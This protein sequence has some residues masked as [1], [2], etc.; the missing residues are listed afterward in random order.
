[1]VRFKGPAWTI[2]LQT[3]FR[4]CQHQKLSITKASREVRTSPKTTK[5]RI[6]KYFGKEAFINY[7][8][9]ACENGMFSSL[10]ETNN[11]DE[12]TEIFT[13]QLNS[14]IDKHAPLKVI[15]NRSNYIPYISKTTKDT[16]FE[17]DEW[18]DS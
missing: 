4:K 7:I 5:K 2:Y 8:R 15:Q 16:M 11:V 1:M 18:K 14:I 17:R 10:Y 9:I 6:Y 13:Q 3:V 12:A